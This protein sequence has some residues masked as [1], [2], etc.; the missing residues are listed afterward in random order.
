MLVLTG[1]IK[2]S[3]TKAARQPKGSYALRLPPSQ[4]QFGSEA[5]LGSIII[6]PSCPRGE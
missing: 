2:V 6:E 1:N 3:S 4:T 5:Q